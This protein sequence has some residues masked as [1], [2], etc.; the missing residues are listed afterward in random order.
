MCLFGMDFPVCDCKEASDPFSL[1]LLQFWCVCSGSHGPEAAP[2]LFPKC[3]TASAS[4]P[5]Q[6]LC[7]ALIFNAAIV[8]LDLLSL[9]P[10]IRECFQKSWP[11]GFINARK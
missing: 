2:L 3:T 7:R 6:H 8:S 4:G 1:L 9:V 5:A 10:T 11:D